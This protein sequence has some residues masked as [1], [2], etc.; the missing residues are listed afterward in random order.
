L[1]AFAD[2]QP[3]VLSETGPI[4]LFSGK[5]RVLRVTLHNPEPAPVFLDVRARLYQASSATTVLIAD[6]PWKK[7]QILPGQ[8]I[9]ESVK[10]D[11]PVVQAETR[12]LVQ[13][14]VPTNRVIGLT[15]LL[16]YPLELIKKLEILARPGPIGA[17]DPDNV[18]K[19]IF[20]SVGKTVVDLENSDWD[21]FKGT[22]AIVGPFSSRV[23][24]PSD[25]PRRIKALARNGVAVLWLRPSPDQTSDRLWPSFYTVLENKAAIVV[26][27]AELCSAL[28]DSPVA[29][30]HLIQLSRL[31]L[32]PAAPQLP[33]KETEP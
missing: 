16:V 22:L 31:A 28:A 17:L 4:T 33:E 25:L 26:A 29:Q 23:K 15:D 19:P 32:H 1:R 7:I 5:N 30:N 6:L 8:T 10:L 11:L 2:G 21:E 18:V 9:I 13:W 12:F 3:V 20:D 27:Q 24:M 14:V